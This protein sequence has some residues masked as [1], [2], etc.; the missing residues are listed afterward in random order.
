MSVTEILAVVGPTACG[1]TRR[2]VQLANA[3]GGEII[4]GDSLQV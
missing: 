1:K 3:F 2:A 4:S